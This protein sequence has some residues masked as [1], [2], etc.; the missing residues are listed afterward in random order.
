VRSHIVDQLR[1]AAPEIDP[2]WEAE[3]RRAILENRTRSGT[4]TAERGR[5]RR[6]G[7]L[8][9]VAAAVAA[10]VGGVIVAREHVPRSDVRPAG[11]VDRIQRIDPSAATPLKLGRT[12]EVVADLPRTF[13]GEE[14]QFS[15]FAE[16]GVLVG[17]VAP[18]LEETT[19]PASRPVVTQERPVMYDLDT[20]RFTLLDDRDRP[21][22]TQIADVVGD[23]T[24][25]V[26]V[27]LVGTHVDTSEFTFY[28]Y[29][30][31][32][33][34]VTTI[35][36]FDDPDGQI[37][38]GHDLRLAGDSAYFSTPAYP[39]KRGQEAVYAVP[40]DGSKP[41]RV[42]ASG[43][44]HVTL[45]GDTLTY[46]VASPRDK[47]EYPRSVTYDLRTGRTRAVP[48]SAH[49][50]ELGFCGAEVTEAWETWCVG[51]VWADE[52]A[53]P[54]RLTIKEPSGRI[55]E[56]A[57]FPTE[58]YNVPVPHD[59]MQLGPWVAVSVT[60]EDG[61]ERTFLVDLDTSE[62]KV[63]PDNTSFGALSPDRSKVL[64]SSF[65]DQRPRQRIVR[66]PAS[67]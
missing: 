42:L 58:P 61:Q 18:V 67:D 47:D 66:V 12:L 57:P 54:A 30:R 51:R 63:F 31:Q 41:P 48:V 59:I 24:V 65:A 34:K 17:D 7:R 1:P 15:S 56:F 36:E 32:T 60:T 33:E 5:K 35:G 20:R 14:V 49:V 38:Y 16:D 52:D 26:W 40:V 62:M 25:V 55:T 28:S 6:L 39:K 19:D 21:E 46:Q 2:S 29:D 50:D 3:T 53:Q 10:L 22:P 27:E 44:M 43:G 4:P 45:S 64:I 9:L 11:P 23:D 37:V 13:D 8:A